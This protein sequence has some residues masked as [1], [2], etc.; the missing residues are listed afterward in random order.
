MGSYNCCSSKSKEANKISI[1]IP[2]L[3]VVTEESRLKILCIL[4][5][6]SHCVCEI[7]EHIDLSQSLISHHLKD[8]KEA[9]IVIDEKKGLRVYYSLTKVGKHIINLLFKI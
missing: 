3:K 1:L 7:T 8:L 2:L 5:Q 4:Q 6:G 9:G